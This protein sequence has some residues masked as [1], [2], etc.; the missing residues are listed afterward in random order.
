M[1]SKMEKNKN[2]KSNNIKVLCLA[3]NKDTNYETLEK[4]TKHFQTRGSRSKLRP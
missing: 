3:P 4:K 1:P 2:K